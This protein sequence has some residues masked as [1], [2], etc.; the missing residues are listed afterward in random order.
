[1]H[2]CLNLALCLEACKFFSFIEYTICELIELFFDIL[3]NKVNSKDLKKT[4][5]NFKKT[6][7]GHIIEK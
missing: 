2:K 6:L 5:F 4:M 3:L 1:M 7:I